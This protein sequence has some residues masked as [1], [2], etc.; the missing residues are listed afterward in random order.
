MKMT[1]P[2]VVDPMVE[3]HQAMKRTKI[4][5]KLRM[6]KTAMATINRDQNKTRVQQPQD[7][8]WMTASRKWWTKRSNVA[9]RHDI[10]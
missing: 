3:A 8:R 5:R 9:D 4:S 2:I 6:L 7:N 10:K 1:T